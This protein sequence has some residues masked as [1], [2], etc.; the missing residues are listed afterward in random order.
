MTGQGNC[1][2]IRVIACCDFRGVDGDNLI[3]FD[4]H[5]ARI[6]NRV[7]FRKCDNPGIRDAS[8]HNRFLSFILLRKKSSLDKDISVKSTRFHNKD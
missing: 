8:N 7:V 2:G 4:H 1:F 5:R 3:I 6:E